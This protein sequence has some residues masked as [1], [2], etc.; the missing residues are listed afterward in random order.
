[1]CC[2][3]VVV[4]RVVVGGW[5]CDV[6]GWCGC[7]VLLSFGV[8]GCIMCGFVCCRVSVRAVVWLCDGVC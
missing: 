3:S 4:L 8:C 1:M 6:V 5:L 7:R 2:D